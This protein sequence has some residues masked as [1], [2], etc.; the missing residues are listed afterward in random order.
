M[1]ITTWIGGA[2]SSPR[3]AE[4]VPPPPELVPEL[5][6]DLC[7]FSSREDL[8]AVI[9]AGIAHA[10]FETIH[11]FHD[12][13]GRV[14]RAL[15]LVILRRRG[16][17]PRY[18]PPVSLALAGEADK[19]VAGLTSWRRGDEEDWYTVFIDAVYRASLG[20]GEFARRVAELQRHWIELAGTPRRGSGPLRLIELLPSQP[21]TDVKT[22]TQALGGSS[23]QARIAI[24]RLEQ[25]GV[26][27]NPAV[28]KRN[29][30]WECVGLF[31]LL[32]SFE[33]E[34]GPAGRT[35]RATRP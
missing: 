9:Q 34:L 1:L 26:L 28:G 32:D 17:A 2:A 13:N 12:G 25:A 14:G 24:L 35:P 19:Y 3:T 31:D 21:I 20:A 8:P 22:A 4:F 10:Q 29:R 33:R 6:D 7:T 16:L 30:A 5:L 11:P 27:R 23:E 15:I 18:L